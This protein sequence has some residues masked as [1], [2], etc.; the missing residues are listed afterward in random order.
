MRTAN[1]VDDI[2]ARRAN[3]INCTFHAMRRSRAASAPVYA[4]QLKAQA[5]ACFRILAAS[6]RH[7]VCA[8]PSTIPNA[9]G[10]R[11]WQVIQNVQK[12]VGRSY[13]ES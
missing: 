1:I 10:T 3:A 8:L 9:L 6:D 4:L 11:P 2:R 12:W 7:V 5:H 13:S